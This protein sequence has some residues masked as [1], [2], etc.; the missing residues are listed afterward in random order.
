MISHNR[1]S[2]LLS[3]AGLLLEARRTAAPIDD[4]PSEL[5]PAS[6]EEAYFVQDAMGWPGC[7]KK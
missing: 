5:Q 4:L 1:E 7:R 2:D 6:L 3:A